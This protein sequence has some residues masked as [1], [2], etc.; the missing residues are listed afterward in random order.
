MIF[1]RDGAARH[2]IRRTCAQILVEEDSRSPTLD[3]CH[4]IRPPFA[5][6]RTITEVRQHGRANLRVI[7]QDI[8]FSGLGLGIEHLVQVAELDRAALYSDHL[9]MRSL[10]HRASIDASI[11]T[12]K[13]PCVD[14]DSAEWVEHGS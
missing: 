2:P 6:R 5:G 12:P 13:Y 14:S 11:W 10:G 7:G 8:G 1:M 3:F 4:T 9:V